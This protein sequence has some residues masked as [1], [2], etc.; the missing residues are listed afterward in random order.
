MRS[1]LFIGDTEV[2]IDEETVPVITK[3]IIDL[4]QPEKR[5]TDR[6]LSFTLPGTPEND[7][8]FGGM[9]DVNLQI[10]NSTDIQFNP[11]FN[12]NLKAA[13][14][15]YV[16]TV[17]QL[18]GYCQLTDIK[19]MRNNTVRY[20]VVAY[21]QT[22]DLFAKI[23]SKQMTE[24]DL[25]EYD[26]PYTK[27]TIE[28]SWDTSIIQN[29]GSVPFELGNGYVYPMIDYGFHTNPAIWQV[30]HF[31]PAVY[32]KTYLDKIFED[33]GFTYQSDFFDSERFKRLVLPFTSAELKI[34]NA[35]VIDRLFDVE[36][37]T[38]A[39]SA[40]PCAYD[41]V[42]RFFDL[43]TATKL[44]FNQE[45]ADPSGQWSTDTATIGAS[46]NYLFQGM[47]NLAFTNN[48]GGALL[49][50]NQVDVH[51]A[52]VL[53]RGGVRTI[54][55][56]QF[57]STIDPGATWANGNTTSFID[58]YLAFPEV[59]LFAG[60]QVFLT[61]LTIQAEG[62]FNGGRQ[63]RTFWQ[64]DG[65]V[66]VN[67]IG[68][69]F[70]NQVGNTQVVEGDTMPVNS[71][72]P[73]EFQQKDFLVALIRM[74]NLYLQPHP[75]I[76]NRLI[77]EPRDD[78]YTADVVDWTYK[79]DLDE[80]AVLEPMGLLDA[81]RYLFQYSDD[82]DYLN[83]LHKS[84]YDFTYGRRRIDV[85]NDFVK[86]DKVIQPFF[87]NTPLKAEQNYTDRIL[88]SIVFVDQNGAP[89]P[90]AAKPRILYFGGLLN[91]SS[92]IFRG[93]SATGVTGDLLVQYPYAGHLDN[94]YTPTFDLCFGAPQEVYYGNAFASQGQLQYTNNNLYRSYWQKYTE[95]TTDKNSKV[96]SA[97]FRLTPADINTLSF[98][99]QY[100]IKDSY[101]RLLEVSNYNPIS[102]APTLCKFIKIKDRQVTEELVED[103]N[104][105][106][107]TIGGDVLPPFDLPENKDDNGYRPEQANV[108]GSGNTIGGLT[109]KASVVGED[110]I[111]GGGIN[112][113]TVVGGDRNIVLAPGVTIVNSAD[114]VVTD[115]NTTVIGNIRYPG[116]AVVEL[117]V[118]EFSGIG[119][120]PL[121]VL[122]NPGNGRFVEIT[123]VHA[124]RLNSTG[125]YAAQ[126]V[127]LQYAGGI[128]AATFAVELCTDTG[129]RPYKATVNPD[130]VDSAAVFLTTVSGVDPSG[131]DGNFIFYIDYIIQDI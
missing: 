120:T 33:A 35:D 32:A 67:A 93:T 55:G 26:H 36:R 40:A 13:F 130:L 19:V 86:T 34:E 7:L 62:S 15:Y 117:D 97:Y 17:E 115:P 78:Y 14:V 96:L 124:R 83:T 104:G 89:Q 60:D 81:E 121:E 108:N 16:D 22:S 59:R 64:G 47:I 10:Q 106:D 127:A 49:G 2:Y 54:I 48:T 102:G 23:G 39:Q 90:Q 44:A 111:V 65:V 25:S 11:D 52:L 51:L 46:G 18:R 6:T 109:L 85:V 37:A 21:G 79:Q 61:P 72:I 87:A 112:N 107:G 71:C 84:K 38:I 68:S 95:E 92:W 100:F 116:R 73:K 77:V 110:N 128:N 123:N 5:K 56:S 94:P 80:E 113:V 1:Q 74:F 43:S 58:F 126:Q 57:S 69:Y 30:K 42:T 101:F 50:F 31:R 3:Q 29:G 99:V 129:E 88:S 27:Q 24:L 119:T 45:N 9:F 118:A 114:Q 53:Q 63:H 66:M 131:G 20:V 75:V 105:G 82:K 76:A 12:P 91:A 125:G 103:M 70:V 28:N 8:L 98:R 122:I 41:P 4:Q